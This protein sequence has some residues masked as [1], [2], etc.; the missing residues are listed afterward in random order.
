MGVQRAMIEFNHV[1]PQIVSYVIII[2]C[3]VSVAG[4]A[5]LLSR[6]AKAHD[7]L[8]RRVAHL[9]RKIFPG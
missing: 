3:V 6:L 7:K 2:I 4:F 5:Y 1:D 8:V 9:E